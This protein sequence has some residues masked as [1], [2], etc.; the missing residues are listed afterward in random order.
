MVVVYL[1]DFSTER[2]IFRDVNVAS[3]Q[4]D[5]IFKV[6]IFQSFGERARAAV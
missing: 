1:K 6:P 3:I 5:A 4:D 2:V